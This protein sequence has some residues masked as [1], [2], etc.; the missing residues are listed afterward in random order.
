[1]QL[2]DYHMHTHFSCDSK[3][4]MEEMCKSAIAQDIP[5]IGFSEHFDLH[6]LEPCQNWFQV[7]QWWSELERCRAEF[8]GRLLIRAGIEVG[9][10]HLYQSEMQAMLERRPFDYALGSLHWVG[11][12]SVFDI[13]Y[14]KNHDEPVTYST[15]F[16]ELEKMTRMGGFDILSHFDVFI[17][18]SQA[19]YGH[20]NAEDYVDLIRP[21]LRNCI[22]H[23]IALDLNTSALRKRA[24]VLTPNLEILRWYAELGGERVT[25]GSDAH[26]PLDVGSHLDVAL[27]IA[28]EAG[29]RYLT[30]FSGRQ[31]EL[32]PM[33]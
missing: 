1:M 14:F 7:D 5:E 12:N 6:P 2:H 11:R 32:R 22:D 27:A 30:Y 24:N 13:N 33:P 19:V 9:E 21:I 25:L 17:R 4:T 20:Y 23:G 26:K 8:A 29:L 18:T 3:A 31:A 16:V 28:K 10:P 15:F